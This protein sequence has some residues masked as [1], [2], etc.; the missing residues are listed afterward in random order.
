MKVSR[1]KGGNEGEQVVMRDLEVDEKDGW[2]MG[3][4]GL[5]VSGGKCMIVSN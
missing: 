4:G 3:G 1:K 5:T 2:R